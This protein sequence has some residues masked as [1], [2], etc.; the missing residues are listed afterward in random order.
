MCIR[1]R[2]NPFNGS[3]D[4][5]CMTAISGGCIYE[6]AENYAA[7]ATTDDGSCVFDTVSDCPGDLNNDGQIGTPDLLAFLASFGTSCE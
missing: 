3:D 5:Y 6:Q 4:S 2:Y 1:D 7:A